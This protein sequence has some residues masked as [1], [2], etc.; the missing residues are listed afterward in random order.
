MAALAKP[1]LD[2]SLREPEWNEADLNMD[3]VTLSY[4]RTLRAHAC[5][6]PAYPVDLPAPQSEQAQQCGSQEATA[7]VEGPAEKNITAKASARC[8]ADL[9]GNMRTASVTIRMSKAECERLHRRATEAGVTVS[10]YVRSCTFEADA[11]RAQVK[12]ALAE[13]RNAGTK[14]ANEQGNKEINL[15]RVFAHVGSLCIGI[16]SRRSA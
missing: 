15:A 4:D 1:A 16:S 8:D 14:G 6:K 10:A 11:L 7:L 5:Y 3:V 13:L 12:A 2:N 9:Y